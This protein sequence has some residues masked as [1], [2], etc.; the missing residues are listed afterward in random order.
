MGHLKP[1]ASTQGLCVV[2]IRGQAGETLTRASLEEKMKEKAKHK[3][4]PSWGI[5]NQH[6]GRC[7]GE[8]CAGAVSSLRIRSQQK[9]DIWVPPCH[10]EGATHHAQISD[11]RNHLHICWRPY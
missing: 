9:S 7:L 11:L 4:L 2:V 5:I 10:N 1:A 3:P 8:D 6:V